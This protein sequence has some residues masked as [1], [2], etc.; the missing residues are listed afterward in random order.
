MGRELIQVLGQRPA[1]TGSGMYLQSFYQEAENRG[2]S[3]KI[4]AA[5]QEGSEKQD[6]ADFGS[7]FIPVEF[8]SSELPFPIFGMSDNMPYLSRAYSSLLDS[9]KQKLL[10][11][12]RKKVEQAIA[13]M[14]DPTILAHHLWLVTASV[15]R[16]FKNLQVIGISHG[17]GIRQL[18]KNPRFASEVRKGI[19]HLN[20]ILALNQHQKREIADKFNISP[21]KIEITG[22]GY[23]GNNFYF[24]GREELQTRE[25][26]N[27]KEIVY[28]G[29]LS[30]SKGVFS[31][32]R[33]VELLEMNDI[34]LTLIGAGDGPESEKIE[35]RAGEVSCQVE[36]TG[37]LD[38]QEVGERLRTAHVFCLPSF[39]EGFALVILEA[40]ACGLRVVSSDIPGVAD[41]LPDIIE[42]KSAITFVDLPPMQKVDFPAEEEL[43][44]YE[45][46]LSHALTEQLNEIDDYSFLSD[47]EY[48]KAVKSLSWS[49]VFAEIEKFL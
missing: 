2:Y 22:L 45:N 28:V 32:L 49:G 25:Q 19:S 33:V 13:D 21:Q 1:C 7:D 29:K 48:I 15:A 44:N 12:Y 16:K 5:V 36:L 42:E 9:E 34:K 8:L 40:L 10:K 47:R 41:Y 26:K 6:C 20:R 11:D 27:I 23:N 31:L 24:P 35:K 17:T 14:E 39:Y 43:K 4:V 3:Q 37:L 38:Q 46:R 30:R 18:Q